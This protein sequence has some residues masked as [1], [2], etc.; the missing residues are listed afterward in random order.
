[1][2]HKFFGEVLPYLEVKKHEEESNN[3]NLVGMPDITGIS[4]KEAKEIL[5]EHEL[6]IDI[7]NLDENE[8]N[9]NEKIVTE[10]QPKKGINI[11][12]GSKVII[13]AQ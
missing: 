1:M 11:N 3:V 2:H 10:Q 13:Y 9:I 5:K 7:E 6:E 4:I 8:E 12:S